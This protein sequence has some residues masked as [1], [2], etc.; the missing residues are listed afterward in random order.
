MIAFR[1]AVPDDAAAIA[2]LARASFTETF[3]YLYR[4]DDLTLF[5]AGHTVESWAAELMD[6]GYAV[7]MGEA[8]GDAVA[9]AK[10]GPRQLPHKSD[11]NGIELRQFYILKPFQGAGHADAMMAW[12]IDTARTRGADEV[13]LSVFEENHRARRFYERHGFEK[14]GSYAF[15]VGTH[16]DTDDLMRLTL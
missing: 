10:L 9:Y 8:E 5:L 7:L 6:P 11:A 4:P 1:D 2:T 15:M 13:V 14:V 12:A 3:G 16:V